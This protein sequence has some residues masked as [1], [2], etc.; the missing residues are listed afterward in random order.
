[1]GRLG[2]RPIAQG[3]RRAR[4]ARRRATRGAVRYRRHHHR[5]RPR[6][7]RFP[8]PNRGLAQD[9]AKAR[10]LVRR[11]FAASFDDGDRADGLV[12]TFVESRYIGH[13]FSDGQVLGQY[14]CWPPLIDSVEPVMKP[15]SSATRKSTPRAISSASPSRPTGM[16]ATIFSS[17]FG[18][19]ARTI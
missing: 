11:D 17:T 18:G 19:T 13:V 5:L 15:A 3:A 7:S 16:R 10:R 6:L 9:A 2:G 8:L 14:M 12:P 4:R 1:M